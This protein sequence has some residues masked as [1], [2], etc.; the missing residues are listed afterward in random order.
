MRD[1]E[2]GKLTR[3]G[4]VAGGAVA[5]TT[6]ML[7]HA[8]W[9]AGFPDRPIDLVVPFPP[10]GG[11]DLFARIVAKGLETPFGQPVITINKPGAA[12]VIGTNYVKNARPDGY[13]LLWATTAFLINTV[14]RHVDYDPVADYDALGMVARATYVLISSP[15]RGFRTV[16][17]LIAYAKTHPGA[18][19][20]GSPG[21]GVSSQLAGDLLRSMAGIKFL[22]VRYKGTVEAVLATMSDEVDFCFESPAAV[23]ANVKSGRLTLLASASE[24]RDQL[25]PD[26][27]TIAETLPGYNVLPWFALVAPRGV[28]AETLEVLRTAVSRLAQDAETTRR[29]KDAGVAPFNLAAAQFSEFLVADRARWS[30]IA[31]RE[32]S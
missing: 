9:A 17:D 26:T 23:M 27:P 1:A 10:G 13:T 2:F 29:L 8:A 11:A 15:K 20:F 24:V 19:K 14:V 31:T 25:Y 28:P 32:P 30:K 4:L 16:N 5:L 22:D 6:P 18:L 12:S 21:I 7:S 3:R